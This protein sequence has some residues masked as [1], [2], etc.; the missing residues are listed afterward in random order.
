[1][2][3]EVRADDLFIHNNASV[4]R[5]WSHA[6]D[7]KNAFQQPV[8]WDNFDDVEREEFDDREASEDHP[9][10]QPFGVICLVLCLDCFHRDIGWIGD[11]DDVAEDF[12]CISEC[13]VQRDEANDS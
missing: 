2:F 1:M 7:E 5:D 13:K 3:Q 12:S 11:S 10:G 6:P 8:E 4:V 9:V